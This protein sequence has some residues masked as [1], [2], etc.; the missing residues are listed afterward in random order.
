[1]ANAVVFKSSPSKALKMYANN[2]INAFL[3][4]PT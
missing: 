4:Q 2:F 3:L 1:M